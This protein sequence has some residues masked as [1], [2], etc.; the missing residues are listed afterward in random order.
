M[1]D[2]DFF[3][4]RNVQFSGWGLGSSGGWRGGV[5]VKELHS[6]G[7][8]AWSELGWKQ[9]GYSETTRNVI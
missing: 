9:I 5:E 8:S 2:T 4:C 6:G 7:A 1:V 3:H